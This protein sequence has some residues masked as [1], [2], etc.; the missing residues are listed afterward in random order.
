MDGQEHHAVN[1]DS[2]ANTV[3]PARRWG[4]SRWWL[5]TPFVVA[6]LTVA[7]LVAAILARNAGK[8][9]YTL[10]D[11]YIHLALSE[12]IA[13]G[14]YGINAG[15]S[16]TP[17]SSIIWPFFL[18]PFA[19]EPWQEDVPLA[20]AGLSTL[21]ALFVML[22]L[23]KRGGLTATPQ[24]PAYAAGFVI[25]ALFCLNL[26][27]ILFTGMEHSL[28]VFI[29]LVIIWGIVVF[30]DTGRVPWWLVAALALGPLVRY[31]LAAISVS[32]MVVLVL[33]RHYWAAILSF[34]LMV[35]FLGA[36][37]VFLYLQGLPMLP[38][39]VLLHSISAHAVL[40]TGASQSGL[41][42]TVYNKAHS[43]FLNVIDAIYLA[44]GR[45]VAAMAA[46]LFVQWLFHPLDRLAPLR[47][48]TVIATTLILLFGQFEGIVFRYQTY[49]IVFVTVAFVYAN[50]SYLNAFC[51][52]T[53]AHY[54]LALAA[55]LMIMLG[56]RCL[57]RTVSI[58]RAANNI[59]QQQYQMHR[60]IT[61]YYHRPVG[62]ND[63]GW[64][65][66]RNPNYVLDLFG[67]ASEEAR[68]ARASGEK[69]WMDHMTKE[70]HVGLAMIYTNWF[71]D[72]IPADWT[73]IAALHLGG[74]QFTVADTVVDFYV[75]NPKDRP[76]ILKALDA[77]KPTLPPRV[78]LDILAPK[79]APE[80]P[81]QAPAGKPVSPSVSSTPAN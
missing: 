8:F 61:D 11:A 60:F 13:E 3:V 59:Y 19:S 16:A 39:S 7:I 29:A 38:S 23:F 41:L 64:T 20:L 73:R 75:T 28:Q 42:A 25:L 78:T 36:F 1:N 55:A 32:A 31:E 57:F 56:W 2:S 76:A 46:I 71:R 26:V 30:I 40:E 48:F 12:R 53:P 22:R 34:C 24:G 80:K 15:E 68:E 21:G 37:S 79:A 4:G 5:V 67:L 33:R 51:W 69:D 70:H 58:P 72:E 47:L 50:M 54:G 77:F 6:L 66:Y 62:V 81:A 45:I 44:E 35:L 9:T 52:R 17:A 49:L 63:L 18:A 74:A 10:D 43:L 27:T 14:H 65:S